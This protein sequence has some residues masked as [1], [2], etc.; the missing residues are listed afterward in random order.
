M[1]RWVFDGIGL[2]AGEQVHLE[3]GT[4]DPEPLPGR[5]MLP[6]LVD[7]HCHLTVGVTP[8]GGYFPGLYEPVPAEHL[9]ATVEANRQAEADERKRGGPAQRAAEAKHTD[10]EV[11]SALAAAGTVAT[12]AANRVGVPGQD[13]RQLFP[14][15]AV[16][17]RPRSSSQLPRSSSP[18]SAIGLTLVTLECVD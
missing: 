16:E 9:L 2:P 13:R 5:F 15:N 8:N 11:Q 14:V 17:S 7:S 18:A 1:T 3:A 10:D 6:G 4:G 12:K